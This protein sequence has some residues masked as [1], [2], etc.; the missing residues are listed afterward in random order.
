MSYPT[1][2]FDPNHFQRFEQ[3]V[4]TGLQNP[5]TLRYLCG[6]N[7]N[8]FSHHTDHGEKSRFTI[9]HLGD[10]I[11][12]LRTHHGKLVAV[13][14]NGTAYTCVQHDNGGDSKFHMEFYP[15]NIVAFRTA[16]HGRYLGIDDVGH[17]R[18]HHHLSPSEEFVEIVQ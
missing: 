17:V 5:K 14:Q 18:G 12:E 13:R 11:I 4:R 7:N 10:G 3:P 16:N 15:P 9:Q 8:L 2:V 6:E 1:Y